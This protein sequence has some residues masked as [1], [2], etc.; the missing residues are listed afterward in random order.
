ML[1]AR[2]TLSTVIPSTLIPAFSVNVDP[3][4][5]TV[6]VP[7][8]E[9]SEAFNVLA[10]FVAT[11]PLLV[12]VL[13][14]AV[15]FNVNVPVALFTT[16]TLM[17]SEVKFNAPVLVNI[18]PAGALIITSPPN[19]MVAPLAKTGAVMLPPK[20]TVAGLEP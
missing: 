12:R 17:L 20:S 9:V 13:L 10:P 3:F 16:A 8:G 2:I 4:P 14:N 6:D 11:V 18:E 7:A 15:L 5:L 19:V 1:I